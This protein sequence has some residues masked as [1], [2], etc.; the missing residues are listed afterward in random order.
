MQRRSVGAGRDNRR[1]RHADAAVGSTALDK[2]GGQLSLVSGVFG[3]FE[4]GFVADA[5]ELVGFADHGD[6]VFVLDDAALFDGGA[7]VGHV[8]GIEAEEGDFVGDVLVNGIDFV[9]RGIVAVEGV[10]EVFGCFDS[11]NIVP[12]PL[13]S[14]RLCMMVLQL[15]RYFLRLRNITKER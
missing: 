15:R 8:F 14:A 4:H 13:L 6:F 2:Q 10:V 11:V 5:G 9:F 12:S 7:E 3:G 1:I